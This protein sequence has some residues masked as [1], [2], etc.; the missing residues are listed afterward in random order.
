MEDPE[1]VVTESEELLEAK[2]VEAEDETEEDF[3]SAV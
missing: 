3:T 1:D 2:E